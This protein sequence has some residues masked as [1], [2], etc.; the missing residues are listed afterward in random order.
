LEVYQERI[1]L[2]YFKALTNGMPAR[3]NTSII[4]GRWVVRML[5]DLFWIFKISSSGFGSENC[6]WRQ[7]CR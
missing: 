3:P 4:L 7:F 2:E 1:S 6:G 5:L